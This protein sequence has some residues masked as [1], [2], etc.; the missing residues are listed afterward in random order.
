MK[1]LAALALLVLLAASCVGVPAASS[2]SRI[3]VGA[4]CDT[5]A[6]SD[7]R[8]ANNRV[9]IATA[10]TSG[11][12]CAQSVVLLVVRDH[13]GDVIWTDALPAAH[14]MGLND[15]TTQAA[16]TLALA[17][18]VRGPTTRLRTTAD[19]APWAQTSGQPGESEFPFRPEDWIGEDTYERLAGE[20][21][22]MF[23]YIQGMESIACLVEFD[24]RLEKIGVQ[25]F[26]G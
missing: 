5:Q 13:S 24:D 15:P 8:G 11:P 6:T 12:N 3:G 18:W 4:A 1:K 17:D 19:L 23:C 16:M 7:W 25:S 22:P 21:S 10:S 20:A 26:P 9:F 14:V 2:E